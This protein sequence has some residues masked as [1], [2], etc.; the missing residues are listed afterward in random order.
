M[1]TLRYTGIR[2]GRES[3]ATKFGRLERGD[4]VA[5]P[6]DVAERWLTGHLNREQEVVSDFELVS[7]DVPDAER[8]TKPKGKAASEAPEAPASEAEKVPDEPGRKEA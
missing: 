2:T 4:T 8:A 3:I 5:V 1:P 6:G 7:D